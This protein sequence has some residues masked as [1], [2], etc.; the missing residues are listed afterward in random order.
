MECPTCQR[1]IT[2]PEGGVNVIPQKLHLGF[3]VEVAARL[4]VMVKS[5][6]MLAL[7][8]QGACSGVL[9]CMQFLPSAMNT[10]KS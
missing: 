7:M 4:A 3:E 1:S 9:L 10:T 8:E 6:V 5:H 2:I